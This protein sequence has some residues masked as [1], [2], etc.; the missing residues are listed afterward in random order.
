MRFS[1]AELALLCRA[2]ERGTESQ[3]RYMAL[4]GAGGGGGGYAARG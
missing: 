2:D 1:G 4:G 3:Q